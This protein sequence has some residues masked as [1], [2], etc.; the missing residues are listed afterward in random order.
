MKNKIYANRLEIDS[1]Y[2]FTC[3][4]SMTQNRK[5]E[6]PALL[7]VDHFIEVK[8]QSLVNTSNFTAIAKQLA[9]VS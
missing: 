1:F 5:P 7:E 2:Q 9:T 3:H 8:T 6:I 4:H